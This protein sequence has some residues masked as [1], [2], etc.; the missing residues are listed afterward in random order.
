MFIDLLHKNVQCPALYDLQEILE[1]WQTAPVITER[2][3][4]AKISPVGGQSVKRCSC[5]T[6]CTK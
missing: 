2:E 3:A 6:G 4:I 1:T 5:A